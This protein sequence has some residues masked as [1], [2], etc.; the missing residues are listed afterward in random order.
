MNYVVKIEMNDGCD[1]SLD[2]QD[3]KNLLIDLDGTGFKKYSKDYVYDYIT[4]YPKSIAVNV[5]PYPILIPLV[6][7]NGEK[8]VKSSPTNY[9]ADNLLKLPRI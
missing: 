9:S 2:C 4:K 1:Y 7:K 3:I 6:S 8:F 5:D